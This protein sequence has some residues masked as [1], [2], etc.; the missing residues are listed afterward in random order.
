MDITLNLT[1]YEIKE[2][3]EEYVNKRGYSIDHVNNDI[4]FVV[5]KGYDYYDNQT[6]PHLTKATVVAKQN[7][8]EE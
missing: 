7:E 1:P 3:I 8:S 5:E 2:A 4:S 6:S